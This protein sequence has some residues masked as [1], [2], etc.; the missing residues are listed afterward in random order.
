MAPQAPP[1]SRRLFAAGTCEQAALPPLGHLRL[2]P[3]ARGSC[4]RMRNPTHVF[5]RPRQHWE[6]L[7]SFQPLAL[8]KSPR[9]GFN[10]SR[11]NVVAQFEHVELP[12]PDVL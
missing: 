2:C 10:L 12:A 8:R 4:R 11:G 5:G 9:L 3:S 7:C 1:R 6:P